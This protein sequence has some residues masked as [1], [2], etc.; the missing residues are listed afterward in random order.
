ME[1]ET[2]N[3]TQKTRKSA[4]IQSTKTT[5]SVASVKS[6][7]HVNRYLIIGISLAV[8]NYGFYTCLANLIIKN[9][10][11]L[12][13]SNLISTATT[14]ILAYILHSKITWKE[15]NPSKLGIYKFLIW[16]AIMAFLLSPFLTQ[17]FSFITPL[18]Q[19][20]YDIS[21][22]IHL[23]FTY[24]FIQSTGAFIFTA[25]ITTILNYFC[26]DKFIFGKSRVQNSKS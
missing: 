19:F 1:T 14:T 4:K 11:F 10:D 7:H 18:Y 6:S 5:N 20:T 12:W 24:E 17:L 16:N 2:S 21:S 23:P 13:L 22:A 3:N 9:N 26:Y 25:I 8:F 15:R